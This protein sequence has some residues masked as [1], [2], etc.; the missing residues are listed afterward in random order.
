MKKKINT[1]AVTMIITT[2]ITNTITT[3]M[4]MNMYTEAAALA[5]NMM[6]MKKKS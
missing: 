4:S 1:N 3:M 6:T 2:M 5:A